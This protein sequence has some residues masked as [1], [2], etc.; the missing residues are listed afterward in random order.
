MHPV[1]SVLDPAQPSQDS[2]HL[3]DR[4]EASQNSLWSEARAWQRNTEP[5]VTSS[6]A[7]QRTSFLF[8]SQSNWLAGCCTDNPPGGQ[9]RN[10]LHTVCKPKKAQCCRTDVAALLN[11]TYSSGRMQS[12]VSKAELQKTQG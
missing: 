6:H 4:A 12:E 11:T 5:P 9:K 8:F 3:T 10:Q 7:M 1:L 2:P